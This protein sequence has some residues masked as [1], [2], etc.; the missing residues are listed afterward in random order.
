MPSNLELR[1]PPNISHIK[2][3]PCGWRCIRWLEPEKKTLELQKSTVLKPNHQKLRICW[4]RLNSKKVLK[5]YSPPMFMNKTLHNITLNSDVEKSATKPAKPTHLFS[6]TSNATTSGNKSDGQSLRSAFTGLGVNRLGPTKEKGE[7][8]SPQKIHVRIPKAQKT[9][10]SHL[11]RLVPWISEIPY[12]HGFYYITKKT[13][14]KKQNP[15]NQFP[16]HCS[17]VFKK[18][19]PSGFWHQFQV[20][21]VGVGSGLGFSH[22]NP[23]RSLWNSTDQ[24]A[25]VHSF[26]VYVI[27]C[28]IYSLYTQNSN[29]VMTD[30]SKFSYECSAG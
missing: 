18:G 7:H 16:F 15:K 28:L 22:R 4:R 1:H 2:L 24:D 5:T 11:S 29:Y 8:L 30:P 23:V 3:C 10:E 26:R 12:D 6:S 9:T 27:F 25:V 19:I 17:F 21:Q 20:S 13:H 14:T